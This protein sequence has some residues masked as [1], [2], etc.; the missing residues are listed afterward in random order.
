MRYTTLTG[1]RK[2]NPKLKKLW[3]AAANMKNHNV[4]V[5]FELQ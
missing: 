3:L 2:I 4:C 5:Q 1:I